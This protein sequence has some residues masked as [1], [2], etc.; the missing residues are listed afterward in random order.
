MTLQQAIDHPKVNV[1]DI[2]TDKKSRYGFG[3]YTYE[4]PNETTDEFI[5]RDIKN[6]EK[7]I[8]LK[9]KNL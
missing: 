8:H 5:E 1:F 6:F 4:K 9:S 3:V 7:A 2:Y